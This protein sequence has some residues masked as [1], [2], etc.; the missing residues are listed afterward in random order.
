LIQIAGVQGAEELGRWGETLNLSL[1][2]ED[3]GFRLGPRI[4]A[5]GRIADPNCYFFADYR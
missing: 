4:N 1:K 5:I 2:P 3:I